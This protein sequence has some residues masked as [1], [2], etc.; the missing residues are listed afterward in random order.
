MPKGGQAY[1]W[2]GKEC[3]TPNMD[4]HPDA[5]DPGFQM[6]ASA[7]E[8]GMKNALRILREELSKYE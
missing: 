8:A 4:W 2:D 3:Y 5:Y 1:V 6:M 7:Y